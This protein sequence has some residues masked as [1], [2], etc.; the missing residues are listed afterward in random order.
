[1]YNAICYHIPICPNAIG[2]DKTH[3]YPSSDPA[4]GHI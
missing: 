3:M 1:M 2:H 4:Y